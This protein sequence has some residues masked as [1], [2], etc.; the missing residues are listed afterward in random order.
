LFTRNHVYYLK[1]QKNLIAYLNIIYFYFR[2]NLRFLFSG[3][4]HRNWKTFRLLQQSYFQG[5]KM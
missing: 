2:M 1:K 4:Y 3:K 5:V